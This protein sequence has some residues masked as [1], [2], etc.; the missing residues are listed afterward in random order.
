MMLTDDVAYNMVVTPKVPQSLH[1][2]CRG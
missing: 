2:T 1:A